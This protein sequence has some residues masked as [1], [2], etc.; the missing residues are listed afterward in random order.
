MELI[1]QAKPE[2]K[3]NDNEVSHEEKKLKRV[4]LVIDYKSLS[5][6]LDTLTQEL[7]SQ[8]RQ[9]SLTHWNVNGLKSKL[10]HPFKQIQRYF[11]SKSFDFILFNET[12]LTSETFSKLNISH[13]DLWRSGYNQYW[14]FSLSRKGYS[15]T[16]ILSRFKPLKVLEG[17]GLEEFDNEG[18]T[19]TLEFKSFFIVSVYVPNSGSALARLDKRVNE[20]DKHFEAYII[21]LKCYKHVLVVG[22]MNVSHRPIDVSL[23][24]IC[25]DVAGF[26]IEERR[27]FSSLL[28]KG[29]VDVFRDLYPTKKQYTW[30]SSYGKNRTQGNCWR[31]DYCITDCEFRKFIDDVVIRDDVQGSD[32]CPV[33]VYF[34]LE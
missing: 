19:L 18:R 14:A 9:L 10:A 26:T 16:A 29:W 28:E 33:E 25:N 5:Q 30:F 11:K 3:I 7:E 34:T 21:S 2:K 1:S 32:H 20:W 22:D 6:K 27:S 15:G 13:N 4:K 24:L 23:P 12:K 31:L 17:I 8:K